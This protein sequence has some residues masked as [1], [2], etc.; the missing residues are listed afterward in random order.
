MLTNSHVAVAGTKDWQQPSLRTRW[1]AWLAPRHSSSDVETRT[2]ARMH[3]VL[4]HVILKPRFGDLA[5]VLVRA[6]ACMCK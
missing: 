6:H 1:E 3:V 5:H 2:P 4:L